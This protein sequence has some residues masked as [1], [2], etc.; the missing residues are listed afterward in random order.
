MRS[1]SCGGDEAGQQ[2]VGEDALGAFVA[3]VD[4]EGDA[5]G[6]EGEVG[7]LLAA[8]ELVGGKAGESFGKGAVVGA[9]FAVA[10]AHLVEGVVERVVSE[11]GFQFHWMAGA[12]GS[13]RAFLAAGSGMAGEGRDGLP[14]EGQI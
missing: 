6:E 2:V 14:G 11:E 9:Q 10:F 5:L 3:A 4:G 1:H 7:G 12:H 13:S 8:L